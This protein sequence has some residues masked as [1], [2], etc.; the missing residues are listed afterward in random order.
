MKAALNRFAPLFAVCVASLAAGCGG[1]GALSLNA[2][3]QAAENTAH[4]GS[5]RAEFTM[6]GGGLYGTGKGLFNN[7][8][9][10][11]R[12]SMDLRGKGQTIHMDAVSQG[13]VLYIKSPLFSGQPGFPRGKTWLKFDLKKVAK[14]YGVDFDSLQNVGPGSGLSVLRGANKLERA[15]TETV[16]GVVTTHYRTRVDLKAAADAASGETAKSLH[17]LIE[18]TGQKTM[19]AEAWIDGRKRVREFRYTQR[20]APGQPLV[21]ITEVIYG[22]GPPVPIPAPPSDKVFDATSLAGS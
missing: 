1:G 16:R 15:G 20:F 18:L 21:T 13:F 6:S 4:Q 22:F 5:A 3:A 11:G 10:S 8:G 9:S 7:N 12:M 17:R 2:V 19:T 14:S